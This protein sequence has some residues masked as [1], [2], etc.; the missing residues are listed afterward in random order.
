NLGYISPPDIVGE[1][2][3]LGGDG[4]VHVVGVIND[5]YGNSLKERV[6]NIALDASGDRFRQVSVKLNIATGQDLTEV[7]TKL[8]HT[9]KSIYLEHAFQFRFLDDNIAMFYEQEL[10]YSRL[11]QIFSAMFVLIGCL[12]LYGLITF[13]AN[14]KGKEIAIR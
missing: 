2:L 7:L 14:R 13:I 12:G 8:E 9:W 6:D 10:K 1:E 11:F 4:I 3:K 5:Y